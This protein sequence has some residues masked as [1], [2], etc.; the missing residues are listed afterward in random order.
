[1][2]YMKERYFQELVGKN[3]FFKVLV[4]RDG[5]ESAIETL[6]SLID[7]SDD[8]EFDVEDFLYEECGLEPDYV[9]DV[10]SIL[11]EYTGRVV[12]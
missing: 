3:D 5:K 7:Q 2:A 8:E 11:Q 6:F 1:M 4:K 10:L 9:F 12:I